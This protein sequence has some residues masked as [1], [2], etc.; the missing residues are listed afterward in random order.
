M[1]QVITRV[2]AKIN[3]VLRVGP[4]RADGYHE[5]ATV[6]HGVSL[7]DEVAASPGKGVSLD[8][9]G[10][11][12]NATP[13]GGGNLA[14]RA[15]QALAAHAGIRANAALRVHKAIPVAAGLAGGSADAAG[16]LLVCRR[17]WE[18]DLSDAELARVAARLGSD[19]PFALGGG[20]ARGGGRGERL[21]RLAVGS[22]LHWVLAVS[23]DGLSTPAVYK[24][25]DVLRSGRRVP[26]PKFDQAVIAALR[27]G[28]AAALG[29][30]L[31]ND[32]GEA[33]A[34]LRPSLD[35]TLRT[36]RELGALGGLVSGSGPTCAFLARDE[37]HAAEL[38]AGLQGSG[39]C[40][41]ALAV[42][43]PAWTGPALRE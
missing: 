29:P 33:A 4:P 13:G 35:D 36:G 17:L 39:V 3:I 5:L 38:A 15:A 26:K 43:G 12:A 25:L 37:R 42:T 23:D 40:A 27:A 31:A 28:D 2:P 22:P 1:R 11:Y 30:A 9:T 7:Y 41:N 14:V 34:D 32:L 8:L 20:V 21:R 18:L 19:V 24:R 10:P 6:F 16:A